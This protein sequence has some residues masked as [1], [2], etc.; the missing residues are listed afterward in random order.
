V[1]STGNIPQRCT[2]TKADGTPCQAWACEGS[3]Y[4]FWHDPD[5]AQA[6]REARARGG[7]ARHGR[8]IGTAGGGDPVALADVGDV[9]PILE[10]AINDLLQLENSVARARALGYLCGQ[11]VKV[12]EVTDL[13]RRLEAL[14]SA[15]RMRGE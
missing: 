5:Q 4:C 14:E 11:A 7:A 8:H 13:E 15:L 10:R 6:R 1:T 9:L 3:A 12:F 2:A